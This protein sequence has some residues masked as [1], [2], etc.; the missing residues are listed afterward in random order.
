MTKG[1]VDRHPSPQEVEKLRLILSTFQDGSGQQ[2]TSSEATL[3]GWRDFE[4]SVA[5]VFGGR[6]QES[7]A[8]FD[9]LIP[10]LTQPGKSVGISCKMRGTLSDTD[11]TGQVTLEL[12][13][14]AG[15]FWKALAK[16]GIDQKNY[17]HNPAEAGKALVNLVE[18]W[19]HAI[20]DIV[21]LSKSTYLVLSWNN[22]GWYQ[23]HRF[24]LTLPNP[25]TLTWDFPS[26]SR[27][28]KTKKSNE[29]DKNLD[30]QQKEQESQGKRLRGCQE[31]V[32]IFE[33][34]GESGGQLKY[35]PLA[36]TALWASERF[37]LEPLPTDRI[38]SGIQAKVADYYPELWSALNI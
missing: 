13:N 5:V 22:D 7:K 27:K 30:D 28:K 9:V 25:E 19:Q 15:K 2:A 11:K 35:Y 20:R 16:Q 12:S 29:Y 23:L 6:A 17:R 36:S 21:D 4:R 3:P 33:W 24:I 18:S 10:D 1:L 38:G 14:S 32:R 31:G 34:Y 8:I 37:K 26:P